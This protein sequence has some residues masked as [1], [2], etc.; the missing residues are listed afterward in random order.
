MT[1]LHDAV[2]QILRGFPVSYGYARDGT[3]YEI[4]GLSLVKGG[5]NRANAIT[6]IDWALTPAAQEL[7]GRSGS[8]Q[9]QSNS[10]TPV[11]SVSPR[12]QDFNV[13]KYD[14]LKYGTAAVRDGL[15]SRWTREVFAM[16][17]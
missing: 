6:F 3:G 4:G 17:K 2:L 11:P 10:K 7:A 13:I 1:F 9:I 16:P 14:F 5:P 12:F 15:V 8:Y